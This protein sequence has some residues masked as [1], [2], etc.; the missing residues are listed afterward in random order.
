MKKLIQED[1]LIPLKREI[2]KINYV[3]SLSSLTFEYIDYLEKQNINFSFKQKLYYFPEEFKKENKQKFIN[4]IKQKKYGFISFTNDKYNRIIAESFL[5]TFVGKDFYELEKFFFHIDFTDKIC[6]LYRTFGLIALNKNEK[7]LYYEL[8]QPFNPNDKYNI[9]F[10]LN[11]SN[12]PYLMKNHNDL[13]KNYDLNFLCKE[14]FKKVNSLENY[15]I[16][17]YTTFNNVDN[18][19]MI[20][21]AKAQ[22][23]T[24]KLAGLII[25]KQNKE[26]IESL[27]TDYE[28]VL[29][30][31]VVFE[32][33]RNNKCH[34]NSY[35][36]AF[37]LYK[38][39]I[40]NY[41]NSEISI[42]EID[43]LQKNLTID[44]TSIMKKHL[45]QYDKCH[46]F[47]NCIGSFLKS[48]EN[49]KHTF[50]SFDEKN[51]KCMI[52][53][54][55]S[56]NEDLKDGQEFLSKVLNNKEI[57]MSP[58]K[59]KSFFDYTYF[60]NKFLT[61]NINSSKIKI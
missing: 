54:I 3:N 9:G 27:I 26:D 23:F 13:F 35:F 12:F 47:L 55:S 18:I 17:K 8:I 21:H 34:E 22:C 57:F 15:K 10:I 7:K 36:Y 25:F 28:E 50:I 32:F 30:Q 59:Y 20:F 41:K 49:F 4:L 33:F 43:L 1:D 5:N 37:N 51:K 24:L 42:E 2:E 61:K 19:N 58:D 16:N 53:L 45:I 38:K 39:Y 6:Q 44:I 46:H 29:S 40:D 48:E 52:S 56:K 11:D 14:W 31:K 60:N